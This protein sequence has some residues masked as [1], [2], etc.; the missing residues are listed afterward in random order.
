MDKLWSQE[1]HFQL[2]WITCLK[3]QPMGQT[4]PLLSHGQLS[5]YSYFKE[6]WD[7]KLLLQEMVPWL[8][9]PALSWYFF[10]ALIYVVHMCTLIPHFLWRWSSKIPCKKWKSANNWWCPPSPCLKQC[11]NISLMLLFSSNK[12]YDGSCFFFLQLPKHHARVLEQFWCSYTLKGTSDVFLF[13]GRPR[14]FPKL[15]SMNPPKVKNECINFQT[16]NTILSVLKKYDW[17][18]HGDPSLLE[19]YTLLAGAV[20]M[21]LRSVLPLSLLPR[22]PTK[23]VY[24]TRDKVPLD[25]ILATVYTVCKW[26][27]LNTWCS[28]SSTHRWSSDRKPWVSHSQHRIVFLA[29]QTLKMEEVH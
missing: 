3:M 22:S 20:T 11:F 18:K 25:S 1:R 12:H 26:R 17:V 4:Y 29:F 2:Y 5:S 6:L 8:K 27:F 15:Q 24:G 19:Y 14:K 7:I 23:A 16:L 13:L 9:P 21:L 28:W 10:K